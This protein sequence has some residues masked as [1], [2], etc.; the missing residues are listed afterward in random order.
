MGLYAVDAAL[1]RGN[2]NLDLNKPAQTEYQI[3]KELIEKTGYHLR[4][5]ELE[6]L[7]KRLEV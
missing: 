6:E 5:K 4:D 3:A 2:L 1:L 7:G